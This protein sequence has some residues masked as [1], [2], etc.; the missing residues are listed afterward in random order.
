M[1]RPRRTRGDLPRAPLELLHPLALPSAAVA[2][3]EILAE[4]PRAQA[5]PLFSL[6]RA[7]LAWSAGTSAGEEVDRVERYALARL[8]EGGCW[9]AAAVV[10]M[11]VAAPP[12]DDRDEIARA[13]LALADWA[14]SQQAQETALAFA[15]LAALVWPRHPRYAWTYGRLLR[16]RGRMREAEH[17]FRRSHRVAVWLG[18][19]EA[20]A[21]CLNSLGVLSYLTG[22]YRRAEARLARG[23]AL[24][25]KRGLRVSRG[26]ILHDLF[27]LELNRQEFARAEEYATG[28][29][30]HYL[31]G[32]DRLPALAHDLA[33]LWMDQGHFIRALPL[34][35]AVVR[36]MDD[37]PER[38]QSYAAAARAAGGAGDREAFEWAWRGAHE[39]ATRFDESRL[40]PAALVDLGRGASS[41]GRWTEAVETFE[42][43]KSVATRHG[44]TGVIAT[45]EAG[46]TAAFAE[47]GVDIPARPRQRK[48]TARG[49]VVAR[50]MIDALQPLRPVAA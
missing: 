35:R 27:V 22:N 28:A 38:F 24:A 43:A 8:D 40:R 45:A 20:Q 49:D 26:E 32:H 13:C 39:I 31:P 4:L 18:D 21:K 12:C 6:Y 5:L 23:L 9:P 44:E 48:D 7:A 3:V 46:L 33:C 10:A 34:L 11:F 14:L 1:G 19:F 30:R 17:W 25:A 15:G 36:H 2:G 41:L 47:R 42:R 29:L 37:P 50:E 16:G